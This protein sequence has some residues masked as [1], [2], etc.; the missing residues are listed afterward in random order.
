MYGGIELGG[1]KVVVVV[2]T[3]PDAIVATERI[4]VT[5]PAET[6]PRAIDALRTGEA[7]AGRSLHA[8]GVG[9]FGPLELRPGHPDHGRIVTTPK[10]GWTGADVV[11][12]V[13]ETF[14]VPVGFDTDVNAAMLGEAR[15]G[16]ARGFA[17]AVYLT[18]GTGIGGG[19]LVAGRL[20]HGLVHPEMGHVPVVR[21]PDDAFP[22]R[23][24]F[25][26]DCLEGMAAGPAL[27]DRFGRRGETL[28]EADRARAVELVAHYLASGIRS[29]VYLLAPE[30]VI[31]GGGVGELPGLIPAARRALAG[32]LAGYPGLPEHGADDFLVTPGLGSL[33]GPAGTLALAIDAAEG[34]EPG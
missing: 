14:G 21:H 26:G 15:W 17:N 3:A 18:V 22:G 29:I 30:R 32:Q 13:R 4:P 34:V 23:C 28:A 11:G 24:P 31:V 20:V 27:A 5:T 8:I 33:A 1:T 12:P 2:G 6:L 7:A 16:A 19:A 25:H 10:P 9:S